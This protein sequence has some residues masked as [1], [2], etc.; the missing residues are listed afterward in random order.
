MKKEGRDGHRALGDERRDSPN[1][2]FCRLPLETY[3]LWTR[4]ISAL[5]ENEPN[6]VKLVSDATITKFVEAT[7]SF[8]P[9]YSPVFA[10][11]SEAELI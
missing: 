9:H 3:R 7:Q 10:S 2:D 5:L 4:L 1:P 8:P 11:F 6:W